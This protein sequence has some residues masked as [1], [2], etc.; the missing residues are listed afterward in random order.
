MPGPKGDLDPL[1]AEIMQEQAAVLSRL[2]TRLHDALTDLNAFD[3]AAA[4]GS[5]PPAPERRD[6]LVGAAGQALWFY[7]IQREV[8]GFGTSD[9]LLADLRI[10]R[11]VRLRMGL[12]RSRKQ[13]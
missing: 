7:V 5:A 2:G 9:E 11:E 4:D 8:L 12:D 3:A 6:Q 13:P 1:S 10:P